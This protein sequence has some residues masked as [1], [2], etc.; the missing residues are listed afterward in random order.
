MITKTTTCPR[1]LRPLQ[2]SGILRIGEKLFPVFQCDHCTITDNTF[3]DWIEFAY[4]F[5]L[6]AKGQPFDPSDISH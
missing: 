4:T 1:C 6:N 5:A 3:A 2:S